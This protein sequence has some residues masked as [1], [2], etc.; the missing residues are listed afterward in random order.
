LD[1]AIQAQDTGNPLVTTGV[2]V[3]ERALSLLG[4]LQRH[5]ERVPRS[6]AL[7]WERAAFAEV[8]DHDG[9]GECIRGFLEKP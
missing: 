2:S 7:A 3:P 4:D 6:G 1:P 5:Q 8:F 9:P